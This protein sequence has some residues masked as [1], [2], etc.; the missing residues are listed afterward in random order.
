M[1]FR[2]TVIA[3]CLLLNTLSAFAATPRC[4]L[5]KSQ[6]D[7]WV[8]AQVN[9]LVTSARAAYESDDALPA[10]HRVLDRINRTLH[11]CKLSAD[12]DFLE[13][14]REFVYYV[15]TVSLDRQPDHE[16]GFN[17]PDKQYFDETR[18]FVEIPDYL[19]QPA[20]LKLVSRWETL[21]KAKAFLRQL[22]STRATDDQLVFFSYISRHLGTP[23]NDNSYRRLLIVVPGNDALDIPD[24]WVQFGISDPGQRVLTRNL[25]VV[26]ARTN[27]NGTFDAYFKDYF[28]TYGRKGSI[29][30]KGRWDLGEG[31]DNCA[32]CHKSG[33]LPIF[34][35]AGSV[36]A[37]ELEAVENV[38]A[39]FRSYGSPRFGGYLDQTKLGPGL[40]TAS[41]E[42]R[43]HRF[44]KTFA[45][46]NVS[47]AM[48]C[49][50]CHNP[51]RLGS[52]NWPFDPLIVSSYVEGGQM[53]YG[54]TLKQVERRRLYENL[55]EEYFATN[56]ARPGIL[57]SWLLGQ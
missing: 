44:G 15:E 37:A 24:K 47:R 8:T 51:Q 35:Q 38:N 10:Y 20:F 52:L 29:S 36:S 19:L 31:D 7:R 46:T 54:M 30:V 14:H 57:K 26:A 16:L 50:S 4:A 40:S 56:D 5:I 34:P 17:V 41:P 13:R 32:L 18:S 3:C 6:P 33:I 23:D 49:Q 39:R 12:A 9:S 55:I 22:N 11:Q 2:L 43:N 21:D 28:R 45:E 53:P 27:A 25:S 1:S 48:T 42:D